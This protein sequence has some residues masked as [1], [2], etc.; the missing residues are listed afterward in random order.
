MEAEDVWDSLAVDCGS[1]LGK[2]G[3]VEYPPD[4]DVWDQVHNS[5]YMHDVSDTE[6][7]DA[8]EDCDATVCA[9]DGLQWREKVISEF[10]TND[11]TVPKRKYTFKVRQAL[12]PKPKRATSTMLSNAN[13]ESEKAVKYLR[14]CKSDCCVALDGEELEKYVLR[15]HCEYREKAMSDRMQ[16]LH[17]ILSNVNLEHA[18]PFITKI[19]VNLCVRCFKLVHGIPRSTFRD[20]VVRIKH[21]LTPLDKRSGAHLSSVAREGPSSAAMINWLDM[22]AQSAGDV[23]PHKDHVTLPQFTWKAVYD[24]CKRDL[25]FVKTTYPTFMTARKAER[26]NIKVRYHCSMGKCDDCTRLK[27]LIKQHTGA[28][29]ERYKAEK[30]KHDEWAARER[31]DKYRCIHKVTGHYCKPG[32]Q[33]QVRNCLYLESDSMDHSKSKIP[34]TAEESKTNKDLE[35]YELHV[36]IVLIFNGL[37]DHIFTYIWPGTFSSGSDPGITFILDALSRIVIPPT[38]T[39]MYLWTDNSSREYKNRFLLGLCHLLIHM[40]VFRTIKEAFLQVGHTHDWPVDGVFKH[41]ARVLRENNCFTAD[42]LAA[43]ISQ[44]YT[45][46][47]GG[48][49]TVIMVKSLGAF[50]CLFLKYLEKRVEGQ[51]VPRSFKIYKDEKGVV[52]HKYRI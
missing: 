17:T 32:K 20:A 50:S 16:W 34:H 4:I 26:K 27:E 49:P 23:W 39:K 30:A 24:K 51:T 47:L 46:P 41:F 5:S 35:K 31:A 13:A 12:V 48:K 2:D 10:K 40:G 1:C 42:E 43:L 9:N 7:S 8:E 25:V 6:E 37:E 18:R 3:E 14:T 11:S 52:R 22:Y 29:R 38:V 33:D 45:S 28:L 15:M 36:T 19:K 44:S 21:G